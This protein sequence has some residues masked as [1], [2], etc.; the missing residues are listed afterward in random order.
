VA[1]LTSAQ[2]PEYSVLMIHPVEAFIS[3]GKVVVRVPAHMVNA[4]VEKLA[5]GGPCHC[6]C[7]G[8]VSGDV[9]FVSSHDTVLKSWLSKELLGSSIA[10][11]RLAAYRELRLRGW[12]SESGP[13]RW[14][15]ANKETVSREDWDDVYRGGETDSE[16]L[17]RRI[18]GRMAT[19]RV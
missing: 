4:P 13:A 14:S 8:L 15:L 12:L 1:G 9:D 7:G 10:R 16:F 18:E 5:Y 17:R 11:V 19:T 2:G 3:E 6:G